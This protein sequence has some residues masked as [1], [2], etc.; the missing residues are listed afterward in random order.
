MSKFVR[1]GDC[2]IDT[3]AGLI[4]GWPCYGR[5]GNWVLSAPADCFG[6]PMDPVL[7]LVITH[8]PTGMRFGYA[9]SDLRK[10]VASLQRYHQLFGESSTARGVM[11]KWKKLPP[12]DKAWISGTRK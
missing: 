6:K 1:I 11:Q 12:K 5:V 9:P 8:E 7:Y 4:K 3:I 10:A 2:Q